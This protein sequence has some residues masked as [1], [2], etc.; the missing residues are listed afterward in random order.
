MWHYVGICS[1]SAKKSVVIVVWD[2]LV[3]E[4][5]CNRYFLAIFIELHVV[6]FQVK[7]VPCTAID[8]LV[9]YTVFCLSIWYPR[10]SSIWL[11][12]FLIAKCHQFVS[13]IFVSFFKVLHPGEI[14]GVPK[15]VDRYH[16]GWA[17]R[18]GMMSGQ[19]FCRGLLGAIWLLLIFPMSQG[20]RWSK[21][22]FLSPK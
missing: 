15:S 13:D 11:K 18:P 20:L 16:H 3:D 1:K 5:H 22:P 2:V 8:R 14:F 17:L 7:D 6:K 4:L 19:P 9:P 21:C 10:W 12:S